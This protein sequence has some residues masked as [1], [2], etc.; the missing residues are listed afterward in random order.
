MNLGLIWAQ[1]RNGVIGRDGQLPWPQV[2]GR[3][4]RT[5]TS[6]YA[7]IMGR[8]TWESLPARYRPL[9]GR[10]NIVL[11]RR[12][13]YPAAGAEVV[14]SLADAAHRAG[15]EFAWV[16]GGGQVYAAAARDATV[17]VVTEVDVDV[18]GDVHAPQL[19]D[20]WWLRSAG[21]WMTS[22]TGV[23]YRVL[24]FTRPAGRE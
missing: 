13:D 9:P 24:R 21:E 11:S 1:S 2:D 14:T 4:F 5:V 20:A 16:I 3:H 10:R 12:P 7:V 18:P 15:D 23:R 17:A 6:G 22:A 8:C 19:G